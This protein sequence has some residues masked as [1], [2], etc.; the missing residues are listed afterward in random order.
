MLISAMKKKLILI[1][2]VI[3]VVI[4]VTL[5]AQKTQKLN[6]SVK[7]TLDDTVQPMEQRAVEEFAQKNKIEFLSSYEGVKDRAINVV[8]GMIVT[9]VKMNTTKKKDLELLKKSIDAIAK[10]VNVSTHTSRII[11]DHGY[12]ILIVEN[13]TENRIKYD[14]VNSTGMSSVSGVIEFNSSKRLDAKSLLNS[15][16]KTISFD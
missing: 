16:I 11:T 2:L 15:I 12:K 5:M 13:S 8:D 7:I 3:Q 6:S 14:V 1:F 10:S 9:S 4:P